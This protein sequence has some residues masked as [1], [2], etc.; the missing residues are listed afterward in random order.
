MT[1]YAPPRRSSSARTVLSIDSAGGP[2]G[3]SAAAIGNPESDRG[4]DE[5]REVGQAADPP[6][7]VAQGDQT[8][9]QDVASQ[10]D[11]DELE[12]DDRDDAQG[13]G[14]GA[15]SAD[16]DGQGTEHGGHEGGQERQ[17]AGGGPERRGKT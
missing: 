8:G 12:E 7:R 2:G 4:D 3:G 5:H 13:L 10:E 16:E 15:A 9:G 11:R 6:Q 1:S 14:S 17:D